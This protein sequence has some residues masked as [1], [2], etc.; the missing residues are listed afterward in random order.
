V[1][2]EYL[3]AMMG[4]VTIDKWTRVVEIALR[5]ALRGDSKAREWLGRHIMGDPIHVHEY[6]FKKQEDVTI[7]VTFE[8][9]Q[10]LLDGQA[11]PIEGDYNVVDAD[12][13]EDMIE[14]D[15]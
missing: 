8:S 9:N 2:R 6:L 12:I 1:E 10:R 7:R 5:Q 11:G 4:I 3:D 15:V 13:A 14:N